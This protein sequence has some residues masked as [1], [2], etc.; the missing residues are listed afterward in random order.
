MFVELLM[1]KNGK[2]IFALFLILT[3]AAS[4]F[5]GVLVY[6]AMNTDIYKFEKDGYALTFSAQNNTKAQA[7]SFKNGSEYQYKKNSNTINFTFEE[8]NVRLD[9]NTIMHYSD[10]SLGVLKKVVG[11]DASSIDR[12]IIFYYNIYKDTKINSTSE[13]FSIKLKNEQE[14]KFKT[15]LI[16]ISENKFILTGKNVRLVLNQDNIIDFGEYVEFEYMDGNVVKVYNQDKFYQTISSESHLLV[17]DVKI[18]LSTAIISK[19][20]KEYISLTNLVINSDDNIDALEEKIKKDELYIEDGD[21]DVPT[22]LPPDTS[23][24]EGDKE[25]NSGTLGDDNKEDN[26]ETVDKNKIEN[27]PSYKVA[28]FTVSALKMEALIEIIDVDNLI[29][30]DTIVQIVENKTAKVI[31]EESGTRGDAQMTVSCADLQPDTEYTLYARATYMIDGTEI[32][33]IFLS[34]IFRSEDLGVSFESKLRTHNGI[35]V[36]VSKEN[37]SK[38]N[39]VVIQ[40]FQSNGDKVNETNVRFENGDTETVEFSGLTSNTEYVVTM[41]QISSQNVIVD[42]GYSESKIVKTLKTKPEIGDLAFS[43]DKK[44]SAFDLAVSSVTDKDYGIQNYRYEVYFVEDGNMTGEPAAVVNKNVLETTAVKVDGVNV[45]RDR[46]YTYVLVLE[47]FDNEKV[48]E[49]TK[50]LGYTMSMNGLRYPTI[51]VDNDSANLTWEKYNSTI[52]IEDPD[53]TIQSNQ[54]TLTYKN[55]IDVSTTTVITSGKNENDEYLIPI[56]VNGLRANDTYTFQVSGLIDLVDENGP[57]S[58]YIGS[59]YVQTG[60]P[61]PLK[62][63]IEPTNSGLSAFAL[64]V[65]LLDPPNI[66]ASYEA[67]TLTKITFQLYKGSS[68]DGEPFKSVT[69]T[70]SDSDPYYSK[71]AEEL[72]SGAGMMLTPATFGAADGDFTELKYT[73]VIKNAYDYTKHPNEIPIQNNVKTFELTTQL[74]PIPDPA[75]DSV[76]IIAITNKNANTYGVDKHSE[77]DN[78]TVF[79]YALMPKVDNRSKTARK[80]NWTVHKCLTPDDKNKDDCTELAGL[81]LSTDVS[82]YS[83]TLPY[84][85]FELSEGTPFTTDDIDLLRRGNTYKFGYTIDLIVDDEPM[86]YPKDIEGG[87]GVTL[88]SRKVVS[89]KQSADIEMYPSYSNMTD[90]SYKYVWKYRIYDIDNA[91]ETNENGERLLYLYQEGKSEPTATGV[92][93]AY[94]DLELGTLNDFDFK[95]VEFNELQGDL[96]M[97]IEKQER[98]NKGYDYVPSEITRQYFSSIKEISDLKYN[99]SVGINRLII[100]FNND[101]AN[102]AIVNSIALV[103]VIVK[104]VNSEITPQEIKI[105]GKKISGNQISIDFLEIATYLNKEITVE[106]DVYYDTGRT[107]FDLE[108]IYNSYVAIQK[109]PTSEGDVAYYK[110]SGGA[111]TSSTSLNDSMFTTNLTFSQTGKH[112]LNIQPYGETTKK[113]EVTFG[114]SGILYNKNYITL[115]ELATDRMTST[116]EP[117]IF[118][119]IIPGIDVHDNAGKLTITGLLTQATIDAKIIMSDK[120]VIDTSRGIEVVIHNTEDPTQDDKIINYQVA[121]FNNKITINGL[122]TNTKY[123]ISFYVYLYDSEAAATEYWTRVS[124]YDV[125]LNSNNQTYQ[126]VTIQ[127]VTITNV[128]A[129]LVENS[130]LDKSLRITFN[131]S[132]VYGYK[133]IKYTLL[134]SN[135]NAIASGSNTILTT[136]MTINLNATPGPT[137]KIQY[138][139]DYTIQLSPYTVDDAGVETVLNTKI[140]SFTLATA[141]QPSIGMRASKTDE[142][143]LFTVS[144]SD[145]DYVIVNGQYDYE[146][147]DSTG[148]VIATTANT[149]DKPKIDLKNRTFTFSQTGYNLKEGERYTFRVTAKTDLKNNAAYTETISTKSI[150]FGST[151]NVGTIT[152]SKNS[153]NS[154]AIDLIFQDS[155]KLMENVA[156]VQFTITNYDNE[157]SYSSYSNFNSNTV[158]Y[159]A[160]AKLYYFTITVPVEET[161]FTINNV[162]IVGLNFYSA[163][164]QLVAQQE[165]T[166]YYN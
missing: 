154:Y 158:I 16:R 142:S 132:L 69:L 42:D 1:K 159:N 8:E 60:E 67:S 99:V 57:S 164:G 3:V 12:P 80:I 52:I 100:E 31:F 119:Q 145:L 7:Y 29:N 36:E 56:A 23:I 162:Y 147:V 5:G 87:E 128:K 152:A 112:T 160:A 111:L 124:L 74:S 54:F 134:D 88:T 107:G 148:N 91:L 157:F 47:F 20:S 118:N 41:T 94:T 34:K 130:Y 143:I 146:L 166:Y 165:V 25:E 139:E 49:Y 163:A 155:Y 82:E 62:A 117:V 131:P 28:E 95:V 114:K 33:R 115:K 125:D 156:Q 48:V 133:G 65:K 135:G 75:D 19:G 14:V 66:D 120:S 15:L 103:D 68:T 70:D 101:V 58:A 11:L 35:S 96:M 90:G 86:L 151:L 83:E 73:L 17:N 63:N 78:T 113:V 85:I 22:I 138:G 59:V 110:Y 93:E 140:D 153:S 51:R 144:I 127:E 40:L 18:N 24:V 32:D 84:T 109:V 121:D 79:A 64:N 161:G 104:P 126:F 89:E 72:Y 106:L 13:G 116:Q 10:G 136:T 46:A 39:S 26:E 61:Q 122:K 149:A 53:S 4:I 92:V 108:S 98:Y 44:N 21:V 102:Q 141:Q 150:V 76:E 81:G 45:V 37:Y 9:E 30:S 50:E 123:E 38:V 137:Q 97:Y 77:L 27:T 2:I 129:T 6:D 43:I 55:S 71:L 105:S